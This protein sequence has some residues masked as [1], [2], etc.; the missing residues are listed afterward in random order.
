MATLGINNKFETTA[1]VCGS[2]G[3]VLIVHLVLGLPDGFLKTVCVGV[4]GLVGLCLN[5]RPYIM[6][7]QVKVG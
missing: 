7:Q 5:G 4:R 1:E 6:V 3:Q 2:P